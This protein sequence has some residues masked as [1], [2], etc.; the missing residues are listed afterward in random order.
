MNRHDHGGSFDVFVPFYATVNGE[1]WNQQVPE[2][3]SRM[4]RTLA[5]FDSHGS[6]CS[7]STALIVKFLYEGSPRERITKLARE[8]AA[9][10]DAKGLYYSNNAGRFA[11]SSPRRETVLKALDSSLQAEIT[12]SATLLREAYCAYLARMAEIEGIPFDE[13]TAASF[14]SGADPAAATLAAGLSAL[15]E[16]LLRS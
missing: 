14:L 5:F 11:E 1:Y 15:R 12:E 10:L 16:R 9:F 6:D 3:F 4:K 2:S 13:P 8:M 7:C